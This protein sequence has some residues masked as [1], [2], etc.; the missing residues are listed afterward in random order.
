MQ[1]LISATS[2]ERKTVDA[3][4]T[5]IIFILHGY[6]SRW[7][8]ALFSGSLR[9]CLKAFSLLSFSLPKNKPLSISVQGLVVRCLAVTYFHMGIHTIIG[10]ESFH[11]P[12]RDGKAWDQLA[13]AAKLKLSNR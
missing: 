9:C 3:N 1:A 8:P 5:K 13:V 12:V 4:D 2:T 7:V 6:F 11:D 10:A